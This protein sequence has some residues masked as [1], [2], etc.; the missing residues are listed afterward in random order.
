M[1][2][3]ELPKKKLSPED[4]AMRERHNHV[5]GEFT[6]ELASRLNPETAS[7][8]VDLFM[9]KIGKPSLSSKDGAAPEENVKE[10]WTE[11]DRIV[12]VKMRRDALDELANGGSTVDILII[13]GTLTSAVYHKNNREVLHI[14]DKIYTFAKEEMS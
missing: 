14:L 4:M 6:S 10:F 3:I 8:I 7:K 13:M 11:F 9:E 5:L 2:T 1:P 12:P